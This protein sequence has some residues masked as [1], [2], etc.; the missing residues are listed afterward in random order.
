[1]PVDKISHYCQKCRHA[2][3][4][5][6]RNCGRCGTRLMIIVFPPSMRHDDGIVPSYYEDHLLE[7]VSLLE[8]QLAQAIEK[9]GMI[10]AFF[11]REAKDIKKEQKFIRDFSN[12]LK[13]SNPDIAEK[14]LA[15]ESGINNKT[16]EPIENADGKQPIRIAVLAAHSKPNGELF[17]HLFGE[18]ARLLE[19]GE[20]KQAFQMLERAVVLSPKNVPLLVFIAENLYRADKFEKSKT[21]LEKAFELQP[22]NEKVLLLLGAIYADAGETANGRKFLS[23]LADDEKTFEL[24]HFVWGIM[25]AFDENWTESIAAFK[26]AA[27]P[28]GAPELNYLIG[29]AYYQL[30]NYEAA[31]NFFDKTFEKDTKYADAHFMKSVIYTIEN[32]L[33]KHKKEI[34]FTTAVKEA[35]AQSADYLSGKK[36]ANAA[37]ALPFLHFK[38]TKKQ[39]LTGG[40]PRLNKFFRE[41]IFK[42]LK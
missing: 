32:N 5:G 13:T 25:A 36:H 1:M 28:N 24:V 18:G 37:T 21:Y 7:R 2:N 12:L 4:A 14:I 23:V 20:E 19:R 40:A 8:L 39:L 26:L 11:A 35:G 38:Q 17:S 10:S 30:K 29:S 6:E 42:A 34:E 27:N 3:R 41:R 16:V 22:S 9:I 31:L 15:T 33:E